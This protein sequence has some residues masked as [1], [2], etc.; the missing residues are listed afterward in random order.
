VYTVQVTVANAFGGPPT[1]AS[2]TFRAVGA[3][4][5]GNTTTVGQAPE[6]LTG[7]S[8]PTNGATQVPVTVNPQIAFSEPVTIPAGSVQLQGSAGNGIPSL[9]GGVD[10]NGNPWADIT[11]APAGT[12]F[13]SITIQPLQVLRYSAVAN[14]PNGTYQIVLSQA[15]QD[16]NQPPLSLVTGSSP[17]VFYTYEIPVLS[18]GAAAFASPGIFVAKDRAYVAQINPDTLAYA[19]VWQYNVSDP[20]N[21]LP[22]GPSSNGGATPLT[23]AI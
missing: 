15:I 3:G 11:K 21:P 23:K 22:L 20:A 13:T 17:I 14:D 8:Y 7:E 19:T 18:F 10:S 5:S 9:I 12:A 4:G 16:L 6:I 2:Y 1:V